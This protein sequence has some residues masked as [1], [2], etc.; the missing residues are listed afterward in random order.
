MS[1]TAWQLEPEWHQRITAAAQ[2]LRARGFDAEAA[3]PAPVG[4]VLGSGLGGFVQAVDVR[5]EA[6]FGDVP[7]FA[8]GKVKA[9]AAKILRGAV[10]GT[11]V[12]ILQ[13]RPHAYEGL[14]AAEVVLPV[15]VMRELGCEVIVL[16]NAA[17]G[18]RRSMRA[19]ELAVLLD[20]I[21]L[22]QSD[23]ARG[24]LRPAAGINAELFGRASRPGALFDPELSQAIVRA[25]RA[26]GIT[27]HREVYASVWGPH[28][29]EPAT[30]G[31][32]RHIGAGVV[33]MST[34]PEAAYLRAVGTRV[35]GLSCITNIAVQHGAVEVN[36]DEVVQVGGQS[37]GEFS[38]LLLAALPALSG[39]S[40]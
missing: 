24:I 16:T 5:A 35:V 23:V 36:H 18:L 3:S 2:A 39:G 32:L 17:G 15:A 7:G 27:L 26:T 4:L 19:G 11:E 20:A 25:A 6:S 40:Q 8:G 12:L 1:S 13:G 33:G 9:H 34:G 22:H 37:G 30:I 14:A 10:G 28:Y 38:R 29:E 21:D 31:W